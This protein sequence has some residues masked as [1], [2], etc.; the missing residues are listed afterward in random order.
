MNYGYEII[1]EVLETAVYSVMCFQILGLKR[2]ETK[3]FWGI[4]ITVHIM[5]WSGL[6]CM[7]ADDMVVVPVCTM[8][9]IG[10]LVGVAEGKLGKRFATAFLSYTVMSIVNMVVSLGLKSVLH[11]SQ[12]TRRIISIFEVLVM[13]VMLCVVRHVKKISFIDVNQISNVILLAFGLFGFGVSAFISNILR[14]DFNSRGAVAINIIATSILMVSFV[15]CFT[16]LLMISHKKSGMEQMNRESK[17][18]IEFQQ[19]YVQEILDDREEIRGMYHDLDKIVFTLNTLFENGH[20]DEALKTLGRLNQELNGK[21]R[22]FVYTHDELADAVISRYAGI[23]EKQNI[24]FQVEVKADRKPALQ[25]YDFCIIL[26]N[27]LSNAIEAASAV[28]NSRQVNIYIKQNQDQWYLRVENTY[29]AKSFNTAFA[30]STKSG[31][32]HGYGIKNIRKATDTLGGEVRLGTEGEY[33]I[34]EVFLVE[35]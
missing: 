6:W 8:L 23:A 24:I 33:V 32:Q 21:Q 2:K 25:G 7:K 30:Q 1:K 3:Y 34:A 15:L 11:I 16:V 27:L 4:M 14:D 31:R 28:E 13:I 10:L 22:Q 35:N 26:S 29:C 20:Y 9:E 12:D 19:N 18:L 17:S 5:V